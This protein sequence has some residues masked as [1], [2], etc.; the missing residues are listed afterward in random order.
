MLSRQ[1]YRYC[2]I[3]PETTQTRLS[4]LDNTVLDKSKR[5]ESGV[6]LAQSIC[7]PLQLSCTQ[8]SQS[9]NSLVLSRCFSSSLQFSLFSMS[10]MCDFNAVWS[11]YDVC[12]YDSDN[13]FSPS[14]AGLDES[15]SLSSS[16]LSYNTSTNC[17]ESYN[18]TN[19]TNNPC[20]ICPVCGLTVI[21]LHHHVSTCYIQHNNPS[22]H[23]PRNAPFISY[24]QP[25]SRRNSNTL[26]Q[27]KSAVDRLDYQQRLNLSESFKR[28]AAASNSNNNH[29]MDEKVI[30][31]LFSP[32]VGSIS[33]PENI[34]PLQ[35]TPVII[36]SNKLH[37]NTNKS[38]SIKINQHSLP[39][40]HTNNHKSCAGNK[41]NKVYS[42]SSTPRASIS[43]ATLAAN[44]HIYP[45]PS[46]L[47]SPVTTATIA[48]STP[49]SPILTAQQPLQARSLRDINNHRGLMA[50]IPSQ[51]TLATVANQNSATTPIAIGT[52]IVS[53]IT[54]WHPHT[55]P[56]Y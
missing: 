30:N 29:P 6:E 54:S 56:S 40:N 1:P 31:L 20:S 10:S 15:D 16:N 25:G 45:R 44:D 41:K 42:A 48:N 19:N 33:M 43:V 23:E 39:H 36:P 2:I 28:L 22:P 51:P 21:S 17:S 5:T 14:P 49:I 52:P 34:E 8:L 47:C 7:P 32:A 9:I 35:L 50:I 38:K 18:Q 3:E 24:S 27:L 13:C 53:P 46:P 55:V 37:R 11:N 12:M 26:N 4:K